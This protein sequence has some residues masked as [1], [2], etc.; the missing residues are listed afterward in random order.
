M[1]NKETFWDF[2]LRVYQDPAVQRACLELQERNGADVNVLLF[3]CWTAAVQGGMTEAER[4]AMFALSRTWGGKVVR[5]LRAVR[6]WMKT[7]G[8]AAPHIDR[9][10]CLQLRE[11]IKRLELAAEK[12]QQEALEALSGGFTAAGGEQAIQAAVANLHGYFA[13]AG[14]ELDDEAKRQLAV[15]VAAAFDPSQFDEVFEAL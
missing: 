5:P 15:I 14:R 7:E 9:E 8:C 12:I 13:A 1:T 6:S 2:S 10:Q 3:C 4:D 11:K